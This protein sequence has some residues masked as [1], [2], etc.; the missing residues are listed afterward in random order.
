MNFN[1]KLMEL[2]KSRGLSQEEFGLKVGVSRQTVSKWELG[3]S[4]PD[5]QRLVQISDFFELSL[6]ELVKDVDV[7]EVRE[8]QVS[9]LNA[10]YED[11]QK[12]KKAVNLV[13]NTF[14]TIGVVGILVLLAIILLWG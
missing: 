9:Q 11:V 5:F 6:D 8:K 1:E 2:R 7:Q 13:L 14:A 10:L 12:S 4:Y 3:Q